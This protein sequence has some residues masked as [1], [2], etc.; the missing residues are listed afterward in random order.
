MSMRVLLLS[1]L[2][3][4]LTACGTERVIEKPVPVEVVRIERTLVPGEFLVLHP[5]TEI[6]EDLT[7]GDALQ[8]WSEDRAI[9]DRQNGQLRA[10]QTLND[11][12][13]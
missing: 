6:P 5:K 12:N 2:M 7:Y 11:G 9:I 3:P 4:W 13:L 1:F 8:L 10:I